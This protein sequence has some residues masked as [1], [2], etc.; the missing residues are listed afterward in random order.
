MATTAGLPCSS[1]GIHQKNTTYNCVAKNCVVFSRLFLLIK[2]ALVLVNS[3]PS[4][5]RRATQQSWK[6]K[7]RRRKLRQFW[8]QCCHLGRCW[9]DV[10]SR[11]PR[12]ILGFRFG[13]SKTSRETASVSRRGSKVRILFSFYP[14]DMGF[15]WDFASWKWGW[16]RFHQW[17]I[18]YV[19][20][21]G[22][23]PQL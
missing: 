8:P 2:S 7:L 17:W 15:S 22:V 21:N 16:T 3:Y 10:G 4:L 11:I 23:Y 1:I 14:S 5:H 6:R 20:E 12:R 18:W 13:I 9:G 19:A